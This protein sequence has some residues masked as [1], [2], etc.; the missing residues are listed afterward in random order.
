MQWLATC[1]SGDRCGQKVVLMAWAVGRMLSG[2]EELRTE[3]ALYGEIL[4]VS[5][6]YLAAWCLRCI[7]RQASLYLATHILHT[8]LA[9]VRHVCEG[10]AY[11][12]NWPLHARCDKTAFA[13][14]Y[15]RGVG[16]VSARYRCGIGVVS[17]R[18]RRGIGA[19]STRYQR[20]ISAVSARYQ[21]SI[22]TATR[23]GT[24]YRVVSHHRRHVHQRDDAHV[25]L[26]AYSMLRR[27]SPSLERYR[28]FRTTPGDL[29]RPL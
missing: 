3:S 1:A 16:A 13:A 21:R 19:V 23:T 29:E 6:T 18:Y 20:G 26:G 7:V 9:S 17:A 5:S 2:F 8:H 22:S 12:S 4:A 27:R 28:S 10:D 15:R 24:W 25:M 11:L 14:R